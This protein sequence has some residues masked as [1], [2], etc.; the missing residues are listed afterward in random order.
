MNF[1]DIFHINIVSL[2]ASSIYCL[3]LNFLWYGP[4]FGKKW[5]SASHLDDSDLS[6]PKFAY[7]AILL[8]I[9]I[10][11]IGINFFINLVKPSSFFQVIGVL[12]IIIIS[13]IIP[14][15]FMSVFW[16]RKQWQVILIDTFYYLISF[17]GI[18]AFIYFL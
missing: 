1:L 4:L 16:Y 17:L 8:S 11:I 18:G 5:I 7:P 14:Q 3:L 6:S 15:A 2:I 9:M 10:Q 12:L 13:F